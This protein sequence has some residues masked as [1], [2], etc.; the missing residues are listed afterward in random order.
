M[1]THTHVQNTP[2][3]SKSVFAWNYL[4]V[5]IFSADI[6]SNFCYSFV[7]TFWRTSVLT[8]EQ[9]CRDT[10]RT[11]PIVGG[12]TLCSLSLLNVWW[13]EKDEKGEEMV[14]KSGH[15]KMLKGVNKQPWAPPPPPPPALLL[16]SGTSG[17]C[18]KMQ[19]SWWADSDRPPPAPDMKAGEG[20]ALISSSGLCLPPALHAD[21]DLWT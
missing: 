2:Q 18:F 10:E 16:C 13:K 6:L 21:G 20:Q 1:F 15:R 4:C 17:V 5:L 11:V 9:K 14:L 12:G 8:A 3:L 19:M 7:T